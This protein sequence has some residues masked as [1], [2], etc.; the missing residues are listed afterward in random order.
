VVGRR[1]GRLSTARNRELC[2]LLRE[3][4]LPGVEFFVETVA[5]YRLLLALRGDGLSGDRGDT[6]AQE[7]GR[8]PLVPRALSPGA[9]G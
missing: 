8:M 2:I 9:M 1:A 3:I 7:A 5:D 4:Q 6:D